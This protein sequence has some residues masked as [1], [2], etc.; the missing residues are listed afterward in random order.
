MSNDG[1]GGEG[2][3]TATVDLTTNDLAYLTQ[4]GLIRGHLYIGHKLYMAGHLDHA[5]THM[6]HPE[7]EL[8]ADIVPA[9][10]GRNTVGF[11][12]PLEALATAVNDD[13]GSEKVDIAYQELLG[14]IGISEAAINQSSHTTAEKLKLAVELLRVAGEEYAIAVVNGK[15]EMHMNIKMLW[16]LQPSPVQLFLTLMLTLTHKNI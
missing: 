15:M 1:E 9:F 3:A 6:K 14:G 8:Y 2:V 10:V 13:L 4:L 16:G 12:Q 11:E 5:K 7:S